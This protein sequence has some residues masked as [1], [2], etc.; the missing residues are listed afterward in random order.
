MVQRAKN[1][2]RHVRR[3]VLLAVVAAMVMT[4]GLVAL[5]DHPGSSGFSI[6]GSVPDS[7]AFLFADDF[8]NVKEL[9]PLNQNTTKLGVIHTD[10]LP[11]LGTSN[12]NGQ[13]DLRNVWFDSNTA[14]GTDWLYFAWERDSNKGSGVIAIEFQQAAAPL[15]CDYAGASQDDLIAGCN[16]W[17]NRDVGDFLLDLGPGGQRHRDLDPHLRRNGLRSTGGAQRARVRGDIEPGQHQG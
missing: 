12:P 1:R 3:G 15:V 16:P 17:A 14:A 4:L 7:G 5:A 6:D 9:G 8:G 10:P 11:T 13:V 2:L